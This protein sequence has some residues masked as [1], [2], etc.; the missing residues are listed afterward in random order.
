M[1]RFVP[2]SFGGGDQAIIREES[3]KPGIEPEIVDTAI[4]AALEERK[5]DLRRHGRW[6]ILYGLAGVGGLFLSIILVFHSMHS[7]EIRA[8][9]RSRNK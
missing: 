1:R 6:D 7:D 2:E 9:F 3:L 5:E 8:N 4:K